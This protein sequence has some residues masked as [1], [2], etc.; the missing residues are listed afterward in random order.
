LPGLCKNEA[1]MAK[2]TGRKSATER[3]QVAEL[4]KRIDNWANGNDDDS[5]ADNMRP[6]LA[7]AFRPEKRKTRRPKNI[8]PLGNASN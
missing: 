1:L 2:K 3:R 6:L 5:Y 4:A 8:C 7:R